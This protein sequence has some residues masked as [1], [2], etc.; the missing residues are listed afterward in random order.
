M[1]FINATFQL[2]MQSY[3]CIVSLVWGHV[4]EFLLDLPAATR[5]KGCARDDNDSARLLGSVSK[6][7]Q[8]T[9]LTVTCMAVSVNRGKTRRSLSLVWHA[10]SVNRDA[11][12]RSLSLVWQGQ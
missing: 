7:R 3:P 6:Q 12:Q 11:T 8:N 4:R 5:E 2:K 10:V 1:H 9:A